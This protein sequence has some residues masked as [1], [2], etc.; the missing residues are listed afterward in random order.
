MTYLINLLPW[1]QRRRHEQIRLWSLFAAGC[2]LVTVMFGFA[3]F[4]AFAWHKDRLQA[5][6]EPVSQLSTLLTRRYQAEQ[7]LAKRQKQEE[8]VRLKRLAIRAW[9]MRLTQLAE[10]LP[11]SAWL[12]SLSLKNERLVLKGKIEQVEDVQTVEQNLRQLAAAGSVEVGRMERDKD[13][14]LI[15]TFTLLVGETNNAA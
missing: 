4:S 12:T 7:A 10:L 15:F 6:R 3:R 8:T 1:R 11:A 14:L 2:L 5:E 13:G 9:D